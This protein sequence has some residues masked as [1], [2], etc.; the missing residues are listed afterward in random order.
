MLVFLY[1]PGYDPAQAVKYTNTGES[2][3]NVCLGR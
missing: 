1:S 3:L 2:I